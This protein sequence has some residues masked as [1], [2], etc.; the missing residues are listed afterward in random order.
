MVLTQ[1]MGFVLKLN[2]TI[3]AVKTENWKLKI[4]LQNKEIK[5]F[6]I[7]VVCSDNYSGDLV[8]SR[9]MNA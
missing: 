5:S 8:Q 2:Q 3:S 6:N 1:T 9:D 4:N 7:S